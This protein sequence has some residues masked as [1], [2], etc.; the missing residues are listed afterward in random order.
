VVGGINF[1]DPYAKVPFALTRPD[2]VLTGSDFDVESI[3]RAGDGPYWVGDEFGPYLLHFDRAGRLLAASVPRPGV[4]APE[5]PQRGD[6]PANI[7]SSKGFEGMTRSPDGR[8]LNP[9]LEGTVAGDPADTQRAT[10]Q[11][12]VAS[13]ASVFAHSP[14]QPIGSCCWPVIGRCRR[15][16]G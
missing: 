7:N 1:T 15:R 6:T 14:D 4:F 10:P 9:L 5:N 12:D 11:V 2:R 8:T 13:L 3:V 16:R